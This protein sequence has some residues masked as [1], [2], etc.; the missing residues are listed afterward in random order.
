MRSALTLALLLAAAPA[1]AQDAYGRDVMLGADPAP[2]TTRVEGIVRRANIDPRCTE[3][4]REHATTWS[5]IA[6]R[7]HGRA[8]PEHPTRW[9]SAQ[10]HRWSVDELAPFLDVAMRDLET[11]DTLANDA[12]ASGCASI[13]IAYLRDHGRA[14]ERLVDILDALPIPSDID[15]ELYGLC[16]SFSSGLEPLRRAAAESY[17][18][19]LE[20]ARRHRLFGSTSQACAAGLERLGRLPRDHELVP[21]T[22]LGSVPRAR[23]Q[24]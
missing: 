8:L 3:L 14:Y 12:A 7:A 22:L 11:L 16:G 21:E 9:T 4:A 6:T 10:A 20:V 19:G 15:P 18:A 23:A 13:T 24:R 5:E 1:S 17:A 2:P